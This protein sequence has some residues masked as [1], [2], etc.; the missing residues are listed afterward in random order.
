MDTCEREAMLI[1]TTVNAR[2]RQYNEIQ[3]HGIDQK[4][5]CFEA[6]LEGDWSKRDDQLPAPRSLRLK[7]DAQVMFV[8]NG[9]GMG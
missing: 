8:K 2:A 3:L 5:W 7:K 4:E 6:E 9:R 1:L